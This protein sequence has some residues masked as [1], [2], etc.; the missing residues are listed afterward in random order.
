M[1]LS[2]RARYASRLLLVLAA[3]KD[4]TPLNASSLSSQT[5]ISVK[6][7]EQIFKPL[8]QAGLIQSLR[9][10]SGG[11]ILAK[12]AAEISL[13]DIVRIMEGGIN[14]THCCEDATICDRLQNC[15]TRGAW[16]NVSRLLEQ[17]LDAISL[18]SLMDGQEGNCLILCKESEELNSLD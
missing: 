9:G 17:E 4:A 5:G 18:D 16:L 10:A 12:A 1:K 2:A 7:I 3:Q 8:K 14:L 13:G 15:P 6:F 11:H